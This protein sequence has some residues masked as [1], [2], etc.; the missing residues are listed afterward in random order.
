MKSSHD[1]SCFECNFPFSSPL[2]C[3]LNGVWFNSLQCG[4]LHILIK[5]SIKTKWS[6]IQVLLKKVQCH[7]LS[8]SVVRSLNHSH[9]CHM[10]TLLH[11]YC[12]YTEIW[13]KLSIIPKHPVLNSFKETS[14]TK[15][16]QHDEQIITSSNASI[17]EAFQ[18]C[19]CIRVNYLNPWLTLAWCPKCHTKICYPEL[20]KKVIQ[21]R[22]YYFMFLWSWIVWSYRFF[23]FLIRHQLAGYSPWWILNIAECV[24]TEI[25][26][27][28]SRIY[29][30]SCLRVVKK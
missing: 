30:P 2:L 7:C 22:L 3:A 13:V 14:S 9:N 20:K 27:L 26:T 21:H 10:N 24:L 6:K 1:G 18:N 19:S 5:H 25:S 4:F 8:S 12:L 15:K 16:W 17:F 23:A 29:V 11:F 28:N